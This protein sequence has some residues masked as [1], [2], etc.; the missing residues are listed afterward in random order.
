LN[1]RYSTWAF[2]L[3]L[4]LAWQA[5]TQNSA[6]EQAGPPR[7]PSLE[8]IQTLLENL[9]QRHP[10]QMQLSTAGQSVDGLSIPLVVITDPTTR[11]ENK[12][13]ILFT[14]LHSGI[15]RSATT[16]ALYFLQWLLSNDPGEIRQQGWESLLDN[17]GS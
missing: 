8:Q 7:W 1:F 10:R 15:E 3:A 13:H 11:D 14:T 5:G 9:H 6:A 2:L 12:E 4:C 16:S 17:R